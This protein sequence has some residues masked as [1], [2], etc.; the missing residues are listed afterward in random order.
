MENKKLNETTMEINEELNVLKEE[1]ETLNKKLS[2]LTAE[3]LKQVTGGEGAVT[4]CRCPECG[5]LLEKLTD[6]IDPYPA[7][8]CTRCQKI[9]VL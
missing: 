4:M 9:L 8:M 2:E 1:I 7:Y 6:F 5:G 3:E